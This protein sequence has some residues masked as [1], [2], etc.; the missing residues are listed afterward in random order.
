MSDD[1][2]LLKLWRGVA[3]AGAVAYIPKMTMESE[4]EDFKEGGLEDLMNTCRRLLFNH[5]EVETELPPSNDWLKKN[6]DWLHSNFH[7]KWVTFISEAIAIKAG[8]VDWKQYPLQDGIIL[9]SGSSYKD[10][11]WILLQNPI[12]YKEELPIIVKIEPTDQDIV[13]KME[14]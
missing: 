9:L 2:F 8:F 13:H 1:P 5:T 4:V 12:L 6:G 10:V 7:D 14:E 3:N 11:R